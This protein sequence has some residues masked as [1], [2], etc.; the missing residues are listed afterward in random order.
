MVITLGCCRQFLQ[1]LR[2]AD[3]LRVLIT[4]GKD[5]QAHPL[6]YFLPHRFGPEDLLDKDF[7]LLLEPRSNGLAS[8]QSSSLVDEGPCSTCHIGDTN[9]KKAKTNHADNRATNGLEGEGGDA[10]PAT[11][12]TAEQQPI[13][14]EPSLEKEASLKMWVNPNQMP[15]SELER[16]AFAAANASYAPYSQCPSGVAIATKR[17]YIYSGSYMESAAYNPGLPALQAAIVAFI[18]GG[19]GSYDEIETAAL[20]ETIGAPVQHAATAR[21]ALKY[22]APEACLHVYEVAKRK[23]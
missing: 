13:S 21:V 6:S 5:P 17:G 1:E 4:D 3:N 19:G 2:E 9:G 22:I 20:V 12:S 8:L 10:A 14:H 7:P 15:I 18:C 11:T 23:L 16:S